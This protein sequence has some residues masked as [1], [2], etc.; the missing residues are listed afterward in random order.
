MSELKEKRRN[1]SNA[2]EQ[3]ERVREKIKRRIERQREKGGL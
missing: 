3:S 2:S 1:L